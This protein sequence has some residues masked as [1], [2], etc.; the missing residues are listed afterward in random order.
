MRTAYPLPSTDRA[1]PYRLRRR[2][3]RR[4]V[5]ALVLAAVLPVL[6]TV[7]RVAASIAERTL[8]TRI[9]TTQQLRSRPHVTPEG[10]PFLTQAITGRYRHVDITSTSSIT[11]DGVTIGQAHVHLNN[12]HV[13]L[14]DV[15]R[16]TVRDVPVRT[17]TG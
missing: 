15:L 16:G 12:V 9:Q 4:V 10:F 3:R 11:R 5:A 14:G 17:G 6:V 13:G 7:D 8:A 2:S 1:G